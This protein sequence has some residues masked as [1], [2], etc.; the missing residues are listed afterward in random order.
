MKY[1]Q[2]FFFLIAINACS[3]GND[4]NKIDE[5][6]DGSEKKPAAYSLD[7]NAL[8]PPELAPERLARL[9]AN[10]DSARQ[11]YEADSTDEMNII[12]YGRR[13]AYLSLYPE[14][15]EVFSKGLELHPK[16]F[17]LYRHRGHRYISTR[18]FDKA[19]DDLEKA[20]WFIAGEELMIEPDGAP[21]KL[22]I[23]LSTT[24]FNVYYHLALAHYLKRDYRKAINTYLECMKVSDNNDLLVATTDWLY[25][26]YRKIRR[27]IDAKK[28]L[29]AI[30][31]DMEIIE[32]ESYLNRLL[33]YKG[34]K[35]PEELLQ[36]AGDQ[37]DNGV[38]IATQ[39]YGVGNWYLIN[40]DREKA[41]EI[42]TQVVSGTSWSA[43]GFIAAEAEL[44][45]MK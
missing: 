24:Q 30:S 14:A 34:T 16:S 26:S 13:L 20:A 33:M 25:M 39:G 35:T 8:Y 40:G 41:K 17:K 29:D 21:N 12:W 10:L 42:F 7:G 28:L 3:V 27:D 6:V 23:P 22:N 5:E 18:Q 1:F 11:N 9:T 31:A 38:T 45:R 15:I 4:Q 36:V 2:F 44:R 32:N 43:F 19:I 37:E